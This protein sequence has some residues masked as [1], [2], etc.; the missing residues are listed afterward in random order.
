MVA[1]LRQM[2]FSVCFGLLLLHARFILS[3]RKII[4]FFKFILVINVI[5]I[6]LLKNNALNRHST[7]L[8]FMKFSYYLTYCKLVIVI[9]K[10][11]NLV[12]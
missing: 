4:T 6:P 12:L 10:D 1:C 11:N 8:S 5:I 9:A 2:R 7:L 3:L